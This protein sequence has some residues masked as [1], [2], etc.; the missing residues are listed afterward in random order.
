MTTG[1][2]S[3]NTTLVKLGTARVECPN[4]TEPPA[5]LCAGSCN[6]ETGWDR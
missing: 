1:C 4:F 5:P 2:K 3:V 6:R